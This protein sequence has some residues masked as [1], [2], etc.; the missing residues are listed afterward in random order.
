MA[1][2]TVSRNQPLTRQLT[3]VDP[4]FEAADDYLKTTIQVGNVPENVP[5][6]QDLSPENNNSPQGVPENSSK[7]HD[8]GHLLSLI[9]QN[10]Y[11]TYDELAVQ[12]KQSRKTIQCHIQEF[13]MHGLLRRIGPAKGGVGSFCKFKL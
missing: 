5:E 3:G 8:Q 4:V 7:N 10:P 2:I 12:T 13:K 9:K 1:N 6:K 11:F